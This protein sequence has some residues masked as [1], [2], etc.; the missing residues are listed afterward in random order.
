MTI[1][2]P[3]F[4]TSN[5]KAV[6]PSE[7]NGNGG[8]TPND[9]S[10]KWAWFAFTDPTTMYTDTGRTTL[11]SAD[12]QGIKGMDNKF[13]ASHYWTD[14]YGLVKYQ[15]DSRGAVTEYH[16]DNF[17]LHT[18]GQTDPMGNTING[19]PD[20]RISKL[21]SITDSNNNSTINLIKCDSNRL[22]HL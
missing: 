2:L 13:G 11:V 5:I 3:G 4:N 16:W 17:Y 7:E 12:N 19:N 21:M 6:V 10:D 1:L 20:Y 14:A 9:L 22:Q 15:M 8:F 18:I